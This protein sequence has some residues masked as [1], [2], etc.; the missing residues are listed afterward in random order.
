MRRSFKR[1]ITA[2][3]MLCLCVCIAAAMPAAASADTTLDKVLVAMPS[4]PIAY[5]PVGNITASSGTDGCTVQSITWYDA[6]GSQLTG[7]F[8]TQNYT[9]VIIVSLVEG[10]S[11]SPDARVYLNN[12]AANYSIDGSTIT[13]RRDYT[14]AI[15]T[16][17]IYKHPEAETVTEGG[18]ASF[19]VSGAYYE[20]INW[21]L[22]NP[23]AT[24]YCTMAE[25]VE[26]FPGLTTDE[27]G[28]T[29]MN[30]Y[31]IPIEM[32]GWRIAAYFNN[33]AGGRESYGAVITVKSDPSKAAPTPE[34]TPLPTPEPTA[35]PSVDPESTS[36]SP[37]HEHEFSD[38]WEYDENEHWHACDCGERTDKA[39][40]DMQWTLVRAATKAEAGEE[41]GTC[42]VC[43]YNGSREVEYT[44]KDVQPSDGIL[45][46]VI[47]G[48]VALIV[49]LAAAKL[50]SDAGKR[51]K[52]RGR[53]SHN[54]GYHGKH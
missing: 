41:R 38:T 8:G 5:M 2:I 42:L 49:V 45:L 34:P 32:N 37:S 7:T 22:Y 28:G 33:P 44:G 35:E 17:D 4:T 19:A 47:I 51:R 24:E 3:L 50:I 1:Y 46:R 40:H 48:I 9:V 15:W 16:P 11:L 27:D 13:I 54:G 26:K 14:P 29:R 31:N 18:F 53:G 30:L 43:G 52:H 10:C 20:K 21:R 39:E 6:S 12:S 23:D 36:A 25:A